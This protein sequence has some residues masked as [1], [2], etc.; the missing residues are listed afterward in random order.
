MSDEQDSFSLS[1]LKFELSGN[2]LFAGFLGAKGLDNI[3]ATTA[4][5]SVALVAGR[6]HFCQSLI[7]GVT[8]SRPV[9]N[10]G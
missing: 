1:D 10:P 7:E 9:D 2:P 4:R 8:R 3:L 6:C 5:N